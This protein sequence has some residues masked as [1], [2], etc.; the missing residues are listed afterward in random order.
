MSD[1]TRRSFL[2]RVSVGVATVVGSTALGSRAATAVAKTGDA[3]IDDVEPAQ[4]PVM[5]YV[6]HGDRN[7]VVLLRGETETVHRD[8]RLAR[9]LLRAS[10]K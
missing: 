2:H 3:E 4:E 9:M 1:V 6:R 7:N 5:A 10:S 8:P